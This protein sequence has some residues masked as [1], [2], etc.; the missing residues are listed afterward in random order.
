MLKYSFVLTLIV[1][2]HETYCMDAFAVVGDMTGT[3]QFGENTVYYDLDADGRIMKIDYTQGAASII[4]KLDPNDADGLPFFL[5]RYFEGPDGVYFILTDNVLRR[6]TCSTKISK[7]VPMPGE[8]DSFSAIRPLRFDTCLLYDEEIYDHAI[9]LFDVSQNRIRAEIKPEKPS[10]SLSFLDLDLLPLN[11]KSVLSMGS[12]MLWKIN[13]QDLTVLG[14]SNFAQLIANRKDWE[15]VFLAAVY[16][17]CGVIKAIAKGRT[18]MCLYWVDFSIF[19]KP[20]IV[21]KSDILPLTA[22]K[23]LFI[24]RGEGQGAVFACI[25]DVIVR[26]ESSATGLVAQFVKDGDRIS[27]IEDLR[28]D[29][30]EEIVLRNRQ[31]GLVVSR[32]KHFDYLSTFTLARKVMNS[33]SRAAQHDVQGN[34]D[35]MKIIRDEY[36]NTEAERKADRHFQKLN[37][38]NELDQNK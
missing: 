28:Y 36:V 7:L 2:A 8:T 25:E 4:A 3:P 23:Y 38:K 10:F 17:N 15:H 32:I 22:G 24:S 9:A 5:G 34:L 18:G 11:S 35:R 20:K 26:G 33:L 30:N 31:R 6:Y 13:I 19:N 29:P 12:Q 27:R 14:S 16:E 1:A 37:I 21:A